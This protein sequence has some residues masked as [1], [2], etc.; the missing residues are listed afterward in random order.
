MISQ[1]RFSDCSHTNEPGCAVVD[2]IKKGEL[3][4]KRYENYL[5]LKQEAMYS[6][7]NSRQIENEKI[8]RMFGSKNEMKQ[9]MK[10]IKN[11]TRR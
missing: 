7:L 5:K 11:K 6:S 9:K 10:E 8:N 3:S 2:S 4:V 1:C